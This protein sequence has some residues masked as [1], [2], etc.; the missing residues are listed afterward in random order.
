MIRA[1]TGLLV[2]LST[3]ALLATAGCGGMAKSLLR[4]SGGFSPT[5]V[6]PP[7]V[8]AHDREWA[9]LPTV[10][11]EADRVPVGEADG[12]PAAQVAVFYVHP[13]TYYSDDNWNQPLTDKSANDRVREDAVRGQATV[14]NGSA[15]VYAPR[16]RQAT[17]YTFM[18]AVDFV[19]VDAAIN[20]AYGDVEAAFSA[21]LTRIGDRPFII[22]GDA[23]G[24]YHALALLAKQVSGKPLRARLVAAYLI[25]IPVP[26]DV[27]TRS[28]PDIPLCQKPTDAGCVFTSLTVTRDLDSQAQFRRRLPVY[29]PEGY[30]ST[31]GKKLSCVNPLTGAADGAAG[32]KQDHLGLV[33]FGEKGQ[34]TPEA[35]VV[36]ARCVEGLLLVEDLPWKYG[37]L[38]NG[39]GDI[40]YPDYKIF[41]MNLRRDVARRVEAFLGRGA[42]P[43]AEAS[44][45]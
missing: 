23:Q 7:P 42:A 40:M 41:W 44:E 38:M 30:E 33:G 5:E 13:T 2:A 18:E 1:R 17:L 32:L 39:Q 16:Y 21:F 34:P 19:S 28:I 27:F 24:S 3:T 35:G 14:F 36:S 10:R 9:A 22:A 43:A 20:V 4:P 26:E 45:G 29:Y 6:P 31:A 25:G 11:D 15:Q 12:Q 37:Q 8:Y